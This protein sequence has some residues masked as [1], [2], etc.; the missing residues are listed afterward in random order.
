MIVAIMLKRRKFAYASKYEA[1]SIDNLFNPLVVF[2]IDNL[3]KF[4]PAERQERKAMGYKDN[5][6]AT[7]FDP[8]F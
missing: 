7:E 3:R 4:K 2:E 6:V 8:N 1:L 5:W